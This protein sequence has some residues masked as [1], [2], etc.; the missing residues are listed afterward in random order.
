V[1]ARDDLDVGEMAETKAANA[2]VQARL[3]LPAVLEQAYGKLRASFPGRRDFVESFFLRRE[4]TAAKK[5]AADE[6]AP[7]PHT[8]V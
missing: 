7:A 6:P 2:E 1:E 4:R 3:A 8:S 5:D